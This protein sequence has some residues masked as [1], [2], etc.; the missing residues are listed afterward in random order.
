MVKK[1]EIYIVLPSEPSAEASTSAPSPVSKLANPLT[2]SLQDLLTS[3]PNSNEKEDLYAVM[4]AN[5][6]Q[7]L[8]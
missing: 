5:T 6:Q 3:S 4:L 1:K 8:N 7:K 2:V